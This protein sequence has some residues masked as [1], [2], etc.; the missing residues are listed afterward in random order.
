MRLFSDCSG[1]CDTCQIYYTGGCLA[2]H[3]DDDY[4]Y[5][6]PEWIAEWANGI[7]ERLNEQDQARKQGPGV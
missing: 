3:G 7:E 5:A 4:V 2:G 1:P 6:S